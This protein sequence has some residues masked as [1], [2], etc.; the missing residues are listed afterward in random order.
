MLYKAFWYIIIAVK[1]SVFSSFLTKV[2]G[3][4]FINNYLHVSFVGKISTW[5]TSELCITPFHTC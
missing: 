2:G 4:V 1:L 3:K 5:I